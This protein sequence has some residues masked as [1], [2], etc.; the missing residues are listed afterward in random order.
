MKVSIN[1]SQA[2]RKQGYSLIEVMVAASIL[3]V[4]VAAAA[5]MS[6][7]MVTQEEINQRVSVSLAAQENA[8]RLYQ[9]G[10][11]EAEVDALL[12]H[13]PNIESLTYSTGSTTI[14]GLPL[15]PLEYMESTMIINTTPAGLNA[16]GEW[17]GGGDTS[18]AETR[19]HVVRAYRYPNRF[20]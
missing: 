10:L 2:Q 8:M 15:T 11:S 20:R 9:L 4:G 3:I 6:L 17:N 5:K 13:N 16:D 12:P 7:I 1:K 18:A 19:T 14:S